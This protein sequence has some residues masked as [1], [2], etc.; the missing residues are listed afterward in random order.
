MMRANDE[1]VSDI[2]NSASPIPVD[3][4]GSPRATP[5]ADTI[6][7]WIAASGNQPWF[8]SRHAAEAGTDRNALDDPLA[9]LRLAG[10]VSAATWV[11]GVGQGYVLTPAGDALVASGTG[12]GVALEPLDPPLRQIAEIVE[13]PAPEATPDSTSE[14]HAAHQ[15]GLNL[16]TPLFVPIVLMA[17]L[18]WFLVGAVATVQGDHSISRYLAE[19]QPQTLLH[20]LGAVTGNDLLNGEWWRLLSACFVHIGLLHLLANLFALGMMGPL[21]ELLWGRWRLAAIYVISGL[22]GSCL[23]MSNQPDAMLAGASGA[24]WG[25]L[26]S[27][28]AW[29]ML[30]RNELLPDVAGEWARRLWLAFLLNAGVSFLP[31]VSWEAHLGGGVAGFVA[32]GLLNALRTGPQ[33]R[34]LLALVFFLALPVICVG[35]LMASMQRSP[36]WGLLRERHAAQ[37]GALAERERL[38][39]LVAAEEA[40]NH[41]VVPRLNRLSPDAVGPLHLQIWTILRKPK[42]DR[43]PEALTEV[44]T[45]LTEFQAI[46]NEAITQLSVPLVGWEPFDRV[47]TR[48]REFAEA[49]AT[50]CGVIFKMLDTPEIPTVSDWNTLGKARRTTD[51]AWEHIRQK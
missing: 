42:V 22:A 9:Q 48:A 20:R 39:G 26:A 27:L 29:L 4:G 14:Q 5:T 41:D 15:F 49:R 10:L 37:A 28:L 17:N 25:V 13:E 32:S 2:T 8:P 43:S 21:A 16:R 24:I 36:A 51:A 18:C 1:V 38:A 35:G 45:K 3:A 6:L 44:R 7:K 30:F 33:P 46:A 47:R 23:A 19:G 34:R 12:V 31:G 40:Y 11:R 50:E